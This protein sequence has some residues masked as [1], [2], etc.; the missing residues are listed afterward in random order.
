[1]KRL[2]V[3]L[4]VA[5]VATQASAKGHGVYTVIGA[6]SDSCESFSKTYDNNDVP[7]L[8]QYKQWLMGYITAVN[9]NA[10]MEN[11]A[12]DQ[13]NEP[14]LG[15]GKA[16]AFLLVVYYYCKANPLQSV[17]LAAV[18]LVEQLELVKE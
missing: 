10:A 17:N 8:H 6:G 12:F 5:L 13:G 1:M 3:V 7:L 11:L 14:K 18:Y 16:D 9:H 4:C 15:K 2:L